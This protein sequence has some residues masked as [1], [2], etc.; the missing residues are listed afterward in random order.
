MGIN[1]RKIVTFGFARLALVAAWIVAIP[2]LILLAGWGQTALQQENWDR[3]KWSAILL[4]PVCKLISWC[5]KIVGWI[6]AAFFTLEPEL[7]IEQWAFRSFSRYKA[8]LFNFWLIACWLLMW[9]AADV[10]GN[11]ALTYGTEFF[12]VRP[13]YSLMAGR[14]I[15]FFIAMTLLL[16]ATIVLDFIVDEILN[17]KILIP[18]GADF[19]KYQLQNLRRG[20]SMPFR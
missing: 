18:C 4:F 9:E 2:W 12:D 17:R 11:L 5:V 20:F 19:G 15:G 6:I 1:R 10:V 8:V 16:L 3:F 14:I 13:P 7:E